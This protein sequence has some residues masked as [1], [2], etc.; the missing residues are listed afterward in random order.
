MIINGRMK[1]CRGKEGRKEKQLQRKIV[2]ECK[3][4]VKQSD[5]ERKGIVWKEK[6]ET[7]KGR[8]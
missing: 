3:R 7:K 4:T 8:K 1:I 2:K 6:E 5:R